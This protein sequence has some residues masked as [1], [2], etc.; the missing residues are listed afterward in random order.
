MNTNWKQDPRLKNM[1]PQKLSMLTEF[2]KRAESAPKDQLF[3]TLM[4]VSAEANQKGIKFS[5]EETDLLISIISANM[6][7]SERQRVE[8]IRMLSKNMMK[9]NGKK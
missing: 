3:Q 2:A 7:P 5:D 6:D 1:N 9:R 4:S 8:T